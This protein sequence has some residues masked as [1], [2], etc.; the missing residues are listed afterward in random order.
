MLFPPTFFADSKTSKQSKQKSQQPSED[1]NLTSVA[2]I[3]V[4]KLAKKKLVI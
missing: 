1:V 4:K 3:S 2:T